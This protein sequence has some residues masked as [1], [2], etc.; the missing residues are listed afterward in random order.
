MPTEPRTCGNCGREGA[1]GFAASSAETGWVCVN[2]DACNARMAKNER[3]AERAARRHEREVAAAERAANAGRC[4]DCVTEGVTTDRKM[5]TDRDGRLR[6]GPRC[7]THWRTRRKQVKHNAHAKRVEGKYRISAEVYWTL[8][9]LQGGRCFGCEVATGRT[10]RLAVDHDHE[11]AK[12]HDHPV[13]EG[14]IDCIRCLLCGQ[15]NQIIG[16]LGIEALCR[17]IQVLTDPPARRWLIRN[18]ENPGPDQ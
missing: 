14:C 11:L 4:V 9:A 1:H 15:C 16:R 13:D 10:K 18:A 6:P 5:A 7:I 17:L 3:A 8:Y 2:A 12:T